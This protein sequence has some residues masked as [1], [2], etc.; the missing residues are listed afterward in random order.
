MHMDPFTHDAYK[1]IYMED[2]EFKEVF[3]QLQGQIHVEEGGDK[4]N[5]L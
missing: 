3:Q 1:E 5:H 2:G 4:D